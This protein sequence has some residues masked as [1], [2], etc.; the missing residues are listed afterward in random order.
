MGNA[1]M[2]GTTKLANTWH[3]IGLGCLGPGRISGLGALDLAG[4]RGLGALDLA[5]YRGL[6]AV[7][8]GQYR[9]DVELCWWPVTGFA[10]RH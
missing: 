6:S 3:G 2:T 1:V 5:G 7:G 9:A 10:Q 8:D 4:Y